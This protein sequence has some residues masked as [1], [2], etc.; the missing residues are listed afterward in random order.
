[1]A[2]CAHCGGYFERGYGYDGK[3]FC[4]DS[5]LTAY[6]EQLNVQ[7]DAVRQQE[8]AHNEKMALEQ[9]KMRNADKE[10]FR[11]ILEKRVGHPLSL[12][13][14]VWNDRLA[15]WVAQEEWEAE[16]SQALSAL[17]KAAG[18][19]LSNLNTTAQW[20]ADKKKWSFIP[21]FVLADCA[22]KE[23]PGIMVPG[24][25]VWWTDAADIA[26]FKAVAD[27]RSLE[28]VKW[29][30]YRWDGGRKHL[31][32]YKEPKEP[33]APKVRGRAGSAIKRFL[34]TVLLLFI[35][36]LA[37]KYV[38]RLGFLARYVSIV[39]NVPVIIAAALVSFFL[40]RGLGRKRLLRKIT[41]VLWFVIFTA[42]FLKVFGIPVPRIPFLASAA[43]RAK[44]IIDLARRFIGR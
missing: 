18:V 23:L 37:F 35:A 29:D 24:S 28:K 33:K 40:A 36:Y 7:Q 32:K 38:P 26:P 9:Q 20:N 13:S 25:H 19:N 2:H 11:P 21:S 31:I 4:S 5:C 3:S 27:H 6:Q 43:G 1:M 12:D 39:G 41:T 14:I 8:Q 17:E 44:G 22:I 10:H 16:T 30:E 34:S 15:A 42:I